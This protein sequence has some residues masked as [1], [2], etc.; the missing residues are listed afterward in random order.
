MP[1]V[2]IFLM[3]SSHVI[4]LAFRNEKTKIKKNVHT[5]NFKR[6][7]M[8]TISRNDLSSD[9]SQKKIYLPPL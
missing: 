5:G 8:L 6:R 3:E 2:I 4:L 9:A 1:Q 7:L